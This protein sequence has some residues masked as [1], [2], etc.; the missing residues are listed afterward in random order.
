MLT[1]SKLNIALI[2]FIIGLGIS[3]YIRVTYKFEDQKKEE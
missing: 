3:I 1:Q 2:L